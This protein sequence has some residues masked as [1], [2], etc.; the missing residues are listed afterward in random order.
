LWLA[1]N[2][3]SASSLNV[4]VGVRPKPKALLPMQ[5]PPAPT[6]A[7]AHD[8]GFQ[9]GSPR[10]QHTQPRDE[11]QCKPR[12]TMTCADAA[13]PRLLRLLPYHS[14]MLRAPSHDVSFP[15]S[16]ADQQLVRDM[17]FS[18]QPQQLS[19]AQ[20][21]WPSAAGMAAVQWGACKPHLPVAPQPGPAFR[22]VLQPVLL[23][24]RSR[25]S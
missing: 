16:D 15:L 7:P 23:C 11:E 24:G 1:C 6:P 25:D 2:S 12:P 8:D 22:R 18:I 9:A 14:C 3:C 19:A 21:P 4:R 10:P 17:R 5:P 20:A 13:P